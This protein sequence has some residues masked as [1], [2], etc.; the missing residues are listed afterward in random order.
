M[1]TPE[2]WSVFGQSVWTNNDVKGWHHHLNAK[3]KKANLPFYSLLQ[4]HD[5]AKM[6][7]INLHLINEN[8]LPHHQRTRYRELQS[9]IFQACDDYSAQNMTISQH[10]D[11]CDQL[12]T[13]GE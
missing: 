1:W 8:R 3:V 4:L 6:I 2:N 7:N 11:T 10:L 5:E 13:S 9:K 12:Y